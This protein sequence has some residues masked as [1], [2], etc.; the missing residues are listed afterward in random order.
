MTTCYDSVV[1]RDGS[2][3]LLSTSA[4]FNQI[5]RRFSDN[6][7]LWSS[8]LV[9]TYIYHSLQ[10]GGEFGIADAIRTGI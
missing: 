7:E 3:C 8:L 4:S 9:I 10:A 5:V 2:R 6:Q 1:H